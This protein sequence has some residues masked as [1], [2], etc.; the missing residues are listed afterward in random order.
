M[1]EPHN[2]GT[3]LSI[4]VKPRSKKQA[5]KIEHEDLCVVLVKAAPTRNQANVEVVK[6]IGRKLDIPA[7]DVR[8]I[9]GEKSTKKILLITGMTPEA[10]KA[11]LMK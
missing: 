6:L 3:L 11:A 4:L 2:K 1:I 10:V 8:I 7:T 5:I 9:S